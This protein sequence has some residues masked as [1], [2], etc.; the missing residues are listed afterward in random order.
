MRFPH[1]G[2]NIMEIRMKE[3]VDMDARDPVR[4]ARVHTERGKR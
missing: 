3:L 2:K 4:L 1:R